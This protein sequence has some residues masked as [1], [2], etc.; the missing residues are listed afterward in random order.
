MSNY[1]NLY[2]RSCKK[3]R[4]SYGECYITDFQFTKVLN[5]GS[6]NDVMGERNIFE[7][8]ED[9]LQGS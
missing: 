4:E 5:K 3:E 2:M 8:Y 6:L 7:S 9:I 1:E